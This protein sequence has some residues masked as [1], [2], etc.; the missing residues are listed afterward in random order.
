V[1]KVQAQAG[2]SL[3]DVYSVRGSIAGIEELLT[4]ELPISHEM[5]GTV[6]SERVTGSILRATSGAIAQNVEF[7]VILA[8]PA[9]ISR[10]LGVSVFTDNFGRV[11]NAAVLLRDN[12]AEREIPLWGWDTNEEALAIRMQDNGAAV[13]VL[14]QLVTSL[15]PPNVPSLLIGDGQLGNLINQIAFRGDSNGFGAGLVTVTALVYL[16]HT[17]VVGAGISSR[18]LPLPS[19]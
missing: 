11:Q 10:V 7:D 16:A 17:D 19:W 3:A 9:G 15:M 14:D 18:G 6:F 2:N 4:R 12:V 5:G 8:A 13:G 1:A